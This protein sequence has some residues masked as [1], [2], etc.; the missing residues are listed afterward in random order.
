MNDNQN[1]TVSAKPHSASTFQSQ[2]EENEVGLFRE[3]YDFLK[4]NKKW[5]LSPILIAVCL[6]T[7][8][9]ALSLSPAAPFI[10]TLF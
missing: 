6:L 2:A 1:D 7:L 9:V 10:Y 5:W 8:I 3:F 4:T